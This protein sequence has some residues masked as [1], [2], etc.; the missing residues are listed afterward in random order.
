MAD[1]TIYLGKDTAD[2]IVGLVKDCVKA[3][4]PGSE[5]IDAAKGAMKECGGAVTKCY[6]GGR[7]LAIHLVW[8]LAAVAITYILVAL[9]WRG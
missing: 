2:A 7:G 5:L 9:G 8:A 3:V 1:G 6:L 4:I